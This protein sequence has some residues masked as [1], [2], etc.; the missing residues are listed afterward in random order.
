[1]KALGKGMESMFPDVH[2]SGNR[3]TIKEVAESLGVSEDSVLRSTK[4]L[5]PDAVQNGK[6]TYL[7]EAMVT[8]VKQ[9]I[10]R[11]HNLRSTAEVQ[12]VTTDM[13]MIQRG[14]DFAEWAL[15][16][17]LEQRNQLTIMAPKAEYFDAVSSSK[18]AL[19]MNDVAKTIDI[20][21]MGRNNLFQFLR[22][23]KI[24]M[25]DNQPYQEHIDAGRFRV[26]QSQYQNSRGEIQ[27]THTTLVYQKGL[28]FILKTLSAS[29]YQPRKTDGAAS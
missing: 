3:M 5:F 16:K 26:V 25:P 20:P 14:V 17:I 1:M 8:I 15:A 11:H 6:T 13:E 23:K 9:K 29:G 18:T 22:D 21:G 12:H 28:Q 2:P 7:D 27:I 24:L 19:H 10:E 4:A